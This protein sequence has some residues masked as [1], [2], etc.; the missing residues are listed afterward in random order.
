MFCEKCG[1]EL[2]EGAHFCE[3]CGQKI[4]KEPA[5]ATTQGAP[6]A[7]QTAPKASSFDVSRLLKNKGFLG[8]VGAVIVALVVIIIIAVQP[9][10]ID[11]N[12][13]V[14]VEF[15]GY[16]TIGTARV[17]VDED[18]L[19]AAIAKALKI[20]EKS[21]QDYDSFFS[22]DSLTSLAKLYACLDLA[23]ATLDRSTELSN[24]D[25][26]TLTF[27]CDNEAAKEYGI[28][29]K[30]KDQKYTVEGL[31]DINII[32]AFSNLTVSF[33]GTAP[34]GGVELEYTGSESV[35]DRWSFSC[36]KSYGLRNG[37]TV[38]IT[39]NINEDY[40]HNNGY[41][42]KETSRTY[43]VSGLDEFV[44]SYSSL[45]EEFLDYTKSEAQDIILAYVAQR[46]DAVC[47]LGQLE[48]A[49]YIFEAPKPDSSSWNNN[50]LY[51]IYKGMVAHAE[52][53]FHNTMVYFPVRF[54]N[55]LSTE[56]GIS[57]DKD[58]GIMGN[59]RLGGSNYSTNGYV[60]PLSAYTDLA[61]AKIAAYQV[62]AGDGFEVFES[63][64]SIASIADISTENMALLESAAMDAINNYLTEVAEEIHA[65]DFAVM[66]YYLL[67]LKNPGSDFSQNNRLYV[68]YQ[69]TM[70]N[71]NGD[72]DP[73][74]FYFAVEFDGLVN[75][76]NGEFMYY[77]NAGLMGRSEL[78]KNSS[79]GNYRLNGYVDGTVMYNELV[80]AN[81]TNY[82]YEVSQELKVFGE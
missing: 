69:A 26:V 25:T 65:D 14:T 63:Y 9:K 15:S 28:V 79:W 7:G 19:T 39:L 54:Y 13:Y 29:F 34:N 21:L 74:P 40:L 52:S 57:C 68:V 46:Y 36:D 23:D 67:T 71:D 5:P 55:I 53:K 1:A 45:T 41:A 43:T 17:V 37:D 38:K 33:S 32:D 10:K 8:G 18:G 56:D 50:E 16:E 76:P 75:L 11:L 44:E 3:K 30:G 6:A 12:D 35:I 2:A 48:Y 47:S 62:E 66:G 60:N 31:A 80:T 24:G 72:F 64:T 82:S 70:T 22:N 61:T 59:S 27:E 77:K 73:T 78:K 81:R 49:G 20:D 58:S 4:E 42:V 51:V